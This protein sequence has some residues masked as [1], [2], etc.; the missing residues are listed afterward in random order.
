MI[1]SINF[2]RVIGIY[3]R[4]GDVSQSSR[5][6]SRPIYGAD[7][8]AEIKMNG[9]SRNRAFASKSGENAT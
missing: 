2:S 6:K 3:V 4:V 9:V 1:C 5:P 7:L 8:A